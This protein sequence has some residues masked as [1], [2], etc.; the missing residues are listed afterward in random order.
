MNNIYSIIIKVCFNRKIIYRMLK[1]Q[2]GLSINNY[3]DINQY[4]SIYE[5]I[6]DPILITVD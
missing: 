2:N 1:S 4:E 6:V 5:I 3:H